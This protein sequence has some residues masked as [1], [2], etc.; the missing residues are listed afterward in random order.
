MLLKFV[1]WENKKKTFISGFPVVAPQ[2]ASNH[3]VLG[4]GLCGCEKST[5]PW[6][7]SISYI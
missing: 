7:P 6:E 4:A 1:A 2:P 5:F 3:S